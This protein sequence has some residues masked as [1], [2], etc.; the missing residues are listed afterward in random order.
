MIK[1]QN[2]PLIYSATSDRVP[3]EV[4]A[5]KKGK[6]VYLTI[7]GHIHDWGKASSLEVEKTIKEYKK[8]GATEAVLYINSGGGFLF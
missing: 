6:T 4:T 1:Q 7:K 5:A 3:L 2:L 8:D